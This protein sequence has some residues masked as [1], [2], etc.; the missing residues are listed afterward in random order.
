MT[1]VCNCF[2]RNYLP[3]KF[4]YFALKMSAQVSNYMPIILENC[5]RTTPHEKKMAPNLTGATFCLCSP[6]GTS[7]ETGTATNSRPLPTA[8][9]AWGSTL[10]KTPKVM[11]YCS[12][13]QPKKKL[14]VSADYRLDPTVPSV[15]VFGYYYGGGIGFNLYNPSTNATRPPLYEK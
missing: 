9:Q 14:V 3:R 15:P 2:T 5:Q 8:N 6:S 11:D 1:M 4:W 13:S 7:V 12:T 10:T